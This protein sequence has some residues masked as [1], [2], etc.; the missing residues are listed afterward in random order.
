MNT[1]KKLSAK[2]QELIHDVFISNYGIVFHHNR[3]SYE[4]IYLPDQLQKKFFSNLQSAKAFL[5]EVYVEFA[6]ST[7]YNSPY[8]GK[9]CW[10]MNTDESLVSSYGTIIKK[11]DGYQANEYHYRN[12]TDA[13]R[14]L[15]VRHAH[16]HAFEKLATM[17][18]DE[19]DTYL[20]NERVGV[21]FKTNY[22]FFATSL[23]YRMKNHE[24]QY[25][26]LNAAQYETMYLYWQQST[27]PF[28][29]SLGWCLQPDGKLT[30]R[31]YGTLVEGDAQT[32]T[33]INRYGQV[34]FQDCK[35]V[36]EA[37][38][39]MEKTNHPPG[40]LKSIQRFFKNVLQLFKANMEL[41]QSTKKPTAE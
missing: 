31:V 34:I 5:E 32:W 20:I 40:S 8:L 39:L 14:S 21:I 15:G 7:E 22:G 12:I 1:Y 24:T 9:S 38:I 35:S 6:F 26:S 4:P 27:G 19:K 28:L 3:H 18:W 13:K 11:I 36:E 2:W 37:A 10:Q 16:P 41:N 23:I 25:M 29:N 17:Q 33:G 30:H